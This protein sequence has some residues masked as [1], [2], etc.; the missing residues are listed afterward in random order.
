M[1]WIAND[2]VNVSSSVLLS[3][4]LALGD[5][6]AL[7]EAVETKFRHGPNIDLGA[8][9]NENTTISA[10]LSLSLA[11]RVLYCNVELAICQL[12]QYASKGIDRNQL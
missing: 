3:S 6:V 9:T 7:D 8:C 4:G 10:S 2:L 12:N 1:L 5:D 11:P